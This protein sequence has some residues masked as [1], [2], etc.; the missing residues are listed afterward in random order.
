MVHCVIDMSLYRYAEQLYCY[1]HAVTPFCCNF[2]SKSMQ[3]CYLKSLCRQNCSKHSCVHIFRDKYCCNVCS[4]QSCVII[5]CV[6]VLYVVYDEVV[7]S[8]RKYIDL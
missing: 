8:S 4:I 1:I 5:Q 3:K 7:N 2:L 6:T